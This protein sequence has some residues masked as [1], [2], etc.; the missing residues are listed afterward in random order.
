MR[1]DEK[2]QLENQ[3]NINT[4]MDVMFQIGRAHV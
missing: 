4:F 3:L 1:E 2:Q